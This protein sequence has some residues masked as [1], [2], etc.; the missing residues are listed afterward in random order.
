MRVSPLGYKER[1]VAG[2]AGARGACRGLAESQRKTFLMRVNDPL[3]NVLLCE[4]VNFFSSPKVPK[5]PKENAALSK[6]PD[7][8]TLDT[9]P[10]PAPEPIPPAP[11][12][13][14][15]EVQQ[16]ED[17]QR[18]QAARRK[19]VRATLIAGET[20]GFSPATEGKKTLLG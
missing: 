15:L 18:E 6:M 8:P 13:S 11:T 2:A 10:P 12:T 14:K 9:T 19:G 1:I 7:P 17:D 5:A 16:A 4:C 20:G 3:S